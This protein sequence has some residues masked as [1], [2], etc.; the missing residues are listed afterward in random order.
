MQQVRGAEPAIARWV[1]RLRSPSRRR[2]FFHA[3][4]LLTLALGS[5]NA[6]T[7]GAIVDGVPDGGAHPYV[8]T[9]VSDFGD[10]PRR[11]CSGVLV[12]S[13]VFVTAS[14]CVYYMHYLQN[15][16]L[17]SVSDDVSV[18]FDN[19]FTPESTMHAGTMH[20]NPRYSQRQ[21]DA[22][23][24]AVVVFD[25]PVGITPATLP[26]AGRLDVLAHAGQLRGAHFTAVG[27]GSTGTVFGGG[28]PA[29]PSDDER[30]AAEQTFDAL[31]AA[32]LRLSMNPA[33]GNGGG[34]HGDSG[35]PNLIPGTDEVVALTIGGDIV[36]RATNVTYRLDA[37][38]ARWFLGQYVTLP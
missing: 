16:Y 8:G 12:S 10:G 24:I 33:T 19:P 14:H 22:G 36:C 32:W 37:P 2:G 11:I 38:G 17:G 7:A 35:G 15:L 29:F 27:Y 18:S 30:R 6:P 31:N 1:P 3:V 25:S 4:V 23:D 20:A 13:T 9:L 34:C 21:S 28:R 5:T 26:V